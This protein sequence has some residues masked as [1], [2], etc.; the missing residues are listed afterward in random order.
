MP[1]T[2]LFV[3]CPVY[4]VPSGHVYV[5]VPAMTPAAHWPS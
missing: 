4:V 2:V 1:V 5:P 3:I